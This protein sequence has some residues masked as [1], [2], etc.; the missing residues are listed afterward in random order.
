LVA[1][2][3]YERISGCRACN[4]RRSLECELWDLR[5]SAD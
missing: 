4:R 2:L 3:R 5:I 1:V